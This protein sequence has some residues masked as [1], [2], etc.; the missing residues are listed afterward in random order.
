LVLG[1]C[2]F[3]AAFLAAADYHVSPSGSDSAAGTLAAPFRTIQRAANVAVPGDTVF[4]HAG[5]YRET[6]TP[7]ASGTAAA[8]IVYRNFNDDLVVVSG[9]DPV[10]GWSLDSGAIHS[11]PLPA[12]F[13]VSTTNQSLQVFADGEMLTLA[14]WPDTT[15]RAEAYPSG[16]VPPVTLSTPAKS[17]ITAFVSKTRDTATNW[18]TGVV[19]DTALPA[20]PDDAFA[21]AK[22]FFQPDNKAWSWTFSGEV[23][24]SSGTQLTFRTRNNSGTDGNGAAY[25][26]GARYYLF[27][28]AEFLDTPGEWFHDRA[29]GRLRL[30]LPDSG[31]PA[32]RVIEVKKRDYAFNLSNRSHITIRGLRLFA[33]T[34][35]TDT[36]A[37]GDALGYDAA[38]NVRYP[39]RPAGTTAAS[40]GVTLQGLDVRYPNHFI[41]V[42]GH[43]FLQWGC[44]TGIVLSGTGHR[45]LDSTVRYCAGNGV[46]LLGRDHLVYNNRFEDV[47][48]AGTDT[49]FIGVVSA[50]PAYDIEIA[51]NTGRRAGRSGITPRALRNSTVGQFRARIHH[52]DIAEF[53]LQDWDVGGLYTAASDGQF[54]RIDH[55]RFSEGLGFISAGIYLDYAKNYLVDRNVVWNVEWGIK[56]HGQNG[57]VNNTLVTHNTITVRNTSATPYGP[58]GIGNG[59]GTNVG[60]VL[61][62]NLIWCNNAAS[63]PGYQPITTGTFFSSA[64]QAGNLVWNG[65]AGSSTDPRWIAPATT[66]AATGVDY[67]LQSGSAAIDAAVPV[68]AYV[69]DGW[70]V[71]DFP[72]AHTGSSA[73]TGALEFGLP[74]PIYGAGA[75]PA[76]SLATPALSAELAP[77][78]SATLRIELSNTGDAPLAYAFVNPAADGYAL[79]SSASPGGPAYEFDDLVTVTGTPVWTTAQTGALSAPIAIGFAFPFYGATYTS[80]RVSTEGH[81]TFTGTA[82]DSTPG[83]TLPNTGDPPALVAPLFTNLRTDA[84]S[85]IYTEQIDADTFIVHWDNIRSNNSSTERATFQVVLRRSG[86]IEFRYDS[87]NLPRASLIGLQNAARDRGHFVA[88]GSTY[89]SSGLLLRFT[90]VSSW[91]VLSP[92]TG[93]LAPG[94]TITL[95]ATISSGTLAPGAHPATLVLQTDDPSAPSTVI[96]LSLLVTASP[97]PWSAWLAAHALPLNSDP[98]EDSD[99]DGLSNLLEYALATDP[100]VLSAQP[101]SLTST[102]TLNFDETRLQVSFLRA[103]PELTYAVE[104][105]PNLATWTT[106]ATNPGA[107]GQQVT[108]ADSE[109]LSASSRRFLRLRVAAP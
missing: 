22:I 32:T 11:A 54:V 108:V 36:A 71:P 41:D 53:G 109:P 98:L 50:G 103:R 9:A 29:A 66:V 2:S 72:D 73:D 86:V 4:I 48:Y 106:L 92:Q 94:A 65:V 107:V 18:T 76:L 33:A 97:S 91:F 80:V 95:F 56:I 59:N 99:A 24:A 27:D 14:K 43:F 84:S 83:G 63:S 93:L 42:S 64:E 38:G 40:T 104:A 61:K 1:H 30:W 52:N 23:I 3:S 51:R 45:L 19:A 12:D 16:V 69:R 68:G 100:H 37:G 96:P 28:K 81:L 90:P 74:A 82:L 57:G 10:S 5:T 21:G 75:V 26:V 78:T 39:W 25:K 105:S 62:N 101:L 31:D 87:I 67:R 34:V 47:A 55:N 17:T 85:R 20:R 44:N 35:T 8:P 77:G 13:F 79:A 89:A 60:T 7:A 15:T 70:T 49:S 102:S 46:S 88:Y 58:F 6:I